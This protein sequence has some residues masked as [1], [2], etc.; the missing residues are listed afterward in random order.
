MNECLED[1]HVIASGPGSG[2]K[3]LPR[4]KV[5]EMV[6]GLCHRREERERAAS[7][8]PGALTR[9]A[10]Q[11]RGSWSPVR[12]STTRR[13]PTRLFRTTLPGCSP[14]TSPTIAASAP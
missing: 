1:A 5:D 3:A 12:R 14:V 4:A 9:R 2:P 10:Q 8:R 7:P 6:D 13:P 11:I